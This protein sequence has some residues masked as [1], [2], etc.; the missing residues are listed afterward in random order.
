[1]VAAV[2]EA[3][4]HPVDRPFEPAKLNKVPPIL[5][6]AR[7]G[8]VT[9]PEDDDDRVPQSIST[10]T[11]LPHEVHFSSADSGSPEQKQARVHI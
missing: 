9:I 7:G 8:A 6:S 10:A 3:L 1:M 4:A 2:Q 5:K 11:V